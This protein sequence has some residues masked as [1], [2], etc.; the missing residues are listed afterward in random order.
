VLKAMDSL[1]DDHRGVLEEIYFH[2]RSLAE[3]A[4][5]LGVPA[6]TV[7]SRSYYALRA[8]RDHLADTGSTK[9]VRA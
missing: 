4:A 9:G 3:A 7:K 5:A 6:G 1:S 8:L 2:G